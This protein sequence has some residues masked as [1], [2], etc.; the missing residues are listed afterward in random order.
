MPGNVVRLLPEG[1]QARLDTTAWVVP[2]IFAW[3]AAE[4]GVVHEEMLRTFNMG[5]GLVVAA[6][7]SRVDALLACAGEGSCA[8]GLRVVGEIV[9]GERHVK[10][11]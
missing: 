10:L 9:D 2:P 3:I 7:P 4:G 8:E 5:L 11:S 6:D 1:L